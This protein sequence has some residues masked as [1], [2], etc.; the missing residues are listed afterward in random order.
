MKLNIE[1]NNRS[2]GRIKKDLFYDVI[3]KTL[4]LSGVGLD[5]KNISV[6]IAL[7]PEK[8]IKSLNKAYRK[9]DAVTDILSFAE[10]KNMAEIRKEKKAV[11]FLGELILCY[12]DIK[13]YAAKNKI[14]P[15]TE[16][17]NVL[18]HGILHLLG[19]Q[20]GQKM[21]YIQKRVCE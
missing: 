17:A 21:F 19:F 8:E 13:K 12:N 20:H 16:L 4:E 14:S 10:Y 1:I 3:R 2:G 18:G 6:S 15:K 5:K 11:I 9:K 7:V